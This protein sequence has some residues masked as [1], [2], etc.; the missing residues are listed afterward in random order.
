L[1]FAGFLST[2]SI[3]SGMKPTVSAMIRLQAQTTE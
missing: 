1:P 2:W 3:T